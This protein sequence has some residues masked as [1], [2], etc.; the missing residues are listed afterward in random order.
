MEINIKLDESDLHPERSSVPNGPIN[1]K[2]RILALAAALTTLANGGAV[3]YDNCA[4]LSVSER[5]K[6]A[7]S[8][9]D[10]VP[11]DSDTLT[12]S[13]IGST[14]VVHVAE[15]DEEPNPAA[16]GFGN[17]GTPAGMTTE[18]PA[19]I[20]PHD[21]DVEEAEIHV[22][23]QGNGT[24]VPQADNTLLDKTGIP[25][26][27]RIHASTRTRNADNTWKKKRSIAPELIAQVEAEYKGFSQSAAEHGVATAQQAQQP[28]NIVLPGQQPTPTP[29]PAYVVTQQSPYVKFMI[30]LGK[31]TQS[32]TNPDAPIPADAV[33]A[34]LRQF[35]LPSMIALAMPEGQA[36]IPQIRAVIEATYGAL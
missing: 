27:A 7:V 26:D 13:R 20:P 3:D 28:A 21:P 10:I 34:I 8:E 30:D 11:P 19:N 36:L 14:D 22:D 12:V 35:G 1:G 18:P 25:W 9:L 23:A 32:V 2:H 6:K 16:I 5:L 31:K 24:I 29:A 17:G 15:N 33:E 4:G